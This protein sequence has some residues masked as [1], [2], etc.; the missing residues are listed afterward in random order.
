MGN[1]E[2]SIESMF[3][4]QAQKQKVSALKE[5]SARRLEIQRSDYYEGIFVKKNW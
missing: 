1:V 4:S 3:K 2:D 5:L